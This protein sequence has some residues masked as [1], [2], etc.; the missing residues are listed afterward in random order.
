MKQGQD[1]HW[2]NEGV[3]TARRLHDDAYFAGFHRGRHKERESLV[4][5]GW[6]IINPEK[7]EEINKAL[8]DPCIYCN[9]YT[10]EYKIGCTKDTKTCTKKQ[11][12]I[13]AN[14]INLYFNLYSKQ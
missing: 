4:N 7:R 5:S 10:K 3:K 8:E 1:E 13:L 9:H 12:H 2:V 11:K 6:L 14:E